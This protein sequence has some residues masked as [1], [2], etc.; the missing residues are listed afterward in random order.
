MSDSTRTIQ[1]RKATRARRQQR[2]IK[3]TAARPVAV[4][5]RELGVSAR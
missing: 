3:R 1:A 5:A 4:I 2:Q